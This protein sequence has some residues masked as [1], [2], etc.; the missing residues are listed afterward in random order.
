MNR[1]IQAFA[2]LA[3]F[4][5]L[6]APAHA[7]LDPVTGTL[8]LQGAL[9]LFAAVVAGVKKVRMRFIAM[10]RSLLGRPAPAETEEAAASDGKQP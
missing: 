8:L 1:F 9:A 3:L 4:A 10:I 6:S 7:Y 5:S 2:T